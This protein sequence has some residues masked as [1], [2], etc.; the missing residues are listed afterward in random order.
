MKKLFLATIAVVALAAGSAGAADIRAPVYKAPP[1]PY[2]DWSGCFVGVSGGGAWGRSKHVSGGPG[3]PGLDITNSYNLSGGIIG[4][5]WGCNYRLGHGVIFGTESDF[6][7]T[8]KQGSA[9][10]IPPFA[11]GAVSGTKEHWLST[12]RVRLGATPTD[13]VLLYVTG[14]LA[15]ARVEATLNFPGVGVFSDTRNRWGWTAGVGGEYALGN[16]WSVKAEYL[17]VGFTDRDYFNP[18]PAAGVNVRSNV[19]LNDHIFRVGVNY[20]FGC[21]FLCGLF[22]KY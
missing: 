15:T 14:G 20:N 6:S 7:W 8:N 12:S 19:P 9:N 11:A 5:T 22:A 2:Y 4:G 18:S 1:I 3:G 13:R 10:D 21:L 16:R 17:Y